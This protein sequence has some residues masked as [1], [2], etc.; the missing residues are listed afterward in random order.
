MKVRI[1]EGMDPAGVFAS[2]IVT[3]QY[4]DLPR[5]V[6]SLY[7]RLLLDHIGVIVGGANQHG[8]LQA[9]E[10]VR[11]WGG[12]PEARIIV[13]GDRVPLPNAAFVNGAMARALDFGDVE[14]EAGHSSEYIV[15]TLLSVADMVEEVS[16]KQFLTAYAVSSEVMCRIGMA[17]KVSAM[18]N[19]HFKLQTIHQWG[20]ICGAAKLLDL[21]VDQTWNAI[22]LGYSCLSSGDTQSTVE[23]NLV[24]RMDHAFVSQNAIN[25]VLLAK[26]GVTGTR[27]VFLGER[28]FVA[29][30]Y[31]FENDPAMFTKDLGS[32]WMAQFSQKLY[33]CCFHTHSAIQ[34][35]R[36]LIKENGID[37]EN[38]A[39]MEF[40]VPYETVIAPKKWDPKTVPE[41]Q[42]SLPYTVATALIKGKVFA[43]DYSQEEMHRTDVRGFMA[44]IKASLNEEMP[45]EGAKL[46][47]ALKDGTVYTKDRTYS[48]GDSVQA[49][50]GW[51]EIVNKFHLCTRSVGI[52]EANQDKIV[53]MVN[54]IEAIEDVRSLIDLLIVP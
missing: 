11:H 29:T 2:W 1:P 25:C 26:A 36:D 17:C 50:L 52:S 53:D 51:G 38:I 22:G 9:Y 45:K 16:G 39:L 44:R 49:P 21:T 40:E 14:R 6:V 18:F 8:V 3:I 30:N 24:K 47:M 31:P 27:K 20:P 41:A 10:Y 33:S 46:K 7:K 43:D 23:G 15:P 32:Q 37:L 28:G 12:K 4:E 48:P 34:I 13:H 35:A 19:E 54:S 5:K 42:F